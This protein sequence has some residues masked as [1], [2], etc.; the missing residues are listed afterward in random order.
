MWGNGEKFGI[1]EWDRRKDI[2]DKGGHP[3]ASLSLLAVPEFD[4]GRFRRW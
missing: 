4:T 3:M 1:V 2:R